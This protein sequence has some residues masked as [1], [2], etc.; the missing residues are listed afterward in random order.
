MR[1]IGYTQVSA[2]QTSEPEPDNDQPPD[3]PPS[4]VTQFHPEQFQG[5]PYTEQAIDTRIERFMGI[6]TIPVAGPPGTK[7]KI[8]TLHAPYVMKTVRWTS[9]RQGAQSRNPHWNTGNQYEQLAYSSIEPAAPL[10]GPDETRIYRTS[11]TYSYCIAVAPSD[12]DTFAVGS[13]AYD[14]LDPDQN[15]LTPQNFDQG[16]IPVGGATY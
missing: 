16:I 5:K 6:A 12:T 13:P 11:G 2:P 15:I 1:P 9:E 4:N 3:Y 10:M 14:L 8:V 7:P